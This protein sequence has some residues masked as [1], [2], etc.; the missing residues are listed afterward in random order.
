[1]PNRKPNR[2]RPKLS[3]DE[4][5]SRLKER[6]RQT[7]THMIR[8]RDLKVGT[9]ACEARGTRRRT[10]A[11]VKATEGGVIATFQDGSRETFQEDQPVWILKR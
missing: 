11:Q 4:I 10:I 7:P 2:T 8:A 3:F 1:M 5:E 6:A 9:C